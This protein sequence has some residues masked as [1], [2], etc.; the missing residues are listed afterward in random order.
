M[1]GNIF[2][3]IIK[4]CQMSMIAVVIIHK[5]YNKVKFVLYSASLV[6]IVGYKAAANLQLCLIMAS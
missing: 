4:Y 6:R 1:D 3:N 5:T 2:E